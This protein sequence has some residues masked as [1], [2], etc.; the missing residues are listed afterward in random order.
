MPTPFPGMDPYLERPG[1][2][3]QVH[4]GLIVDIQRY[5]TPHL[6]PNYRVAIEQRTYLSLLPPS[7]QLMGRPDV[8]VVDPPQQGQITVAAVQPTSPTTVTPI[9]GELPLPETI[10]ERYL[11][12][13]DVATQNVITVI[14]ILSPSNKRA[15]DGRW[16]Y[17]KKRLNVLSSWTNLVE[18]DL[19]R[20]GEPLT[21]QVPQKSDYRIVVSRNH[22]RPK[23]EFYLFDLPLP[24]PSIPIPLRPGDS[25][26]QV[27][28]NQILHTLYDD[29]GYDLAID[30]SHPPVPDLAADQKVWS[31]EILQK[32]QSA[33]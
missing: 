7:E 19:L 31:H 6:R 21:M 20:G 13:R 28:L 29:A 1:L 8:L 9:T 27:P 26:P 17:E 3:E 4:A 22:Q 30:Y 25:E 10:V 23:A 2:W 24:I 18:I 15:G 12:I 33:G 14:E 32:H 16:Q 5:L 11:E